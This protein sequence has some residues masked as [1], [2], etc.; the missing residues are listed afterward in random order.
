MAPRRW[1]KSADGGRFPVDELLAGQVA[2]VWWCATCPEAGIEIVAG[3][4]D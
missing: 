1:E 4:E 3:V 2:I